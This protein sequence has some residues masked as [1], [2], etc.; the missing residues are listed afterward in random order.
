MRVSGLAAI[1]GEER[2]VASVLD[3]LDATDA[4]V[5]VLERYVDPPFLIAVENSLTIT[6]RSAV[7]TG[8]I[9]RGQVRVDDLVEWDLAAREHRWLMDAQP[10]ATDDELAR[11]RR[12]SRSPIWSQWRQRPG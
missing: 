7:V 1:A 10:W 2:W 9:E 4:Y 3:L 11:V 5:P 12:F 8:A 6:G